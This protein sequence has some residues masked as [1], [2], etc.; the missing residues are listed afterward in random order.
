[1]QT[2]TTVFLVDDDAAALDSLS[3]LM[4]SAGHHAETYN[5]AVRFL[6]AY[7]PARPGC[8]VLDLCMP[9]MTGLELQERLVREGRRIP[10]I[11]VTAHGDVPATVRALKAG[12]FD[13]VEKPVDG[14]RLLDLVQRALDRD[15]QR[16]QQE[17]ER[18]AFEMLVCRLSPR[19]LE[20]M[21]L[22]YDGKSMK[23]IAAEFG[24]S[25]QTVAKHRAQVLEKMEVDGDAE[26]VRLIT[27][28]RLQE[29]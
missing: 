22:L 18:T 11:F 28:H 7:D 24:I 16:R 27:T 12:A 1:V 10:I 13:F 23:K 3:W 29:P 4:E 21:E 8:L 26:L 20:V 17:P 19:E 6:N 5:S 15:R 14:D 9:E 25:V 2:E